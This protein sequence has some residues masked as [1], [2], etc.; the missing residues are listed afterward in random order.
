MNPQERFYNLPTFVPQNSAEVYVP[1][2][3][4][5]MQ[6]LLKHY[7]Q[8]LEGEVPWQRDAAVH[9]PQD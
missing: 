1:Q 7:F 2:S 4:Q 3:P 5:K 9:N 8:T 6:E